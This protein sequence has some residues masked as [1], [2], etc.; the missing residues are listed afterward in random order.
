MWSS[1]ASALIFISFSF[2]RFHIITILHIMVRYYS[3]FIRICNLSTN[4]ILSLLHYIQYLT[5]ANSR[6]EN[7]VK[8]RPMVH[9]NTNNCFRSRMITKIYNMFKKNTAYVVN[10]IQTFWKLRRMRNCE[11]KWLPLPT[12]DWQ[13]CFSRKYFSKWPLYFHKHWRVFFFGFELL[14]Q[15]R[16][17]FSRK[18][19]CF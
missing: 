8:K 19:I 12:Y 4:A 1:S 13:L 7:L 15:G 14:E 2:V 16:K 17:L 11:L 6:H 9:L 5:L 18:K 10:E 3:L